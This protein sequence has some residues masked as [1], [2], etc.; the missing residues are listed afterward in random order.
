MIRRPPRSTLFPYTTLFRSASSYDRHHVPDPGQA[1][2]EPERSANERLDVGPRHDPGVAHRDL[3]T[4]PPECRLT[5]REDVLDPLR[6]QP[7][8]HP[9]HEPVA[10][11]QDRDRRLIAAPALPPDMFDEAPD[12]DPALPGD[13]GEDDV[14]DARRQTTDTGAKERRGWLGHPLNRRR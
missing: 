8:W 13:R 10:G 7:E 5:G 6:A 9:D 14:R 12:G 3:G 4:A 2:D 11:P 1:D